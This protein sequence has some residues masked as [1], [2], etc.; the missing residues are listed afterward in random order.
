MGIRLYCPFH[1]T[2]KTI[3]TDLQFF[4]ILEK[5]AIGLQIESLAQFPLTIIEESLFVTV[6][7]YI[8]IQFLQINIKEQAY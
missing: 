4:Y 1:K 6:E 5:R 8:S 2:V 3:F 7:T